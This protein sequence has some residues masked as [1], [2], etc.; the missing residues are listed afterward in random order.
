MDEPRPKPLTIPRVVLRGL[1]R[2][3]PLCGGGHVFA[4]FFTKKE[5]CPR[6]AFP[7]QREEGHW[8]GALGMNTIVTFGLM[9]LTLGA[10]AA[11]TWNDR[12]VVSMVGP[13]LAVAV[14]TPILFFGSSQTLWSGID[15]LM[16]PLEPDD[17][18][19]P[20]WIPPPVKR[21]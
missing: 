15:L 5:R 19:D 11:L 17:D 9:A 12:R 8:I 18:A 1:F 7:L 14:L 10:S 13:A 3:C 16:R 6:C 2:R 4:T 21:T 20:R